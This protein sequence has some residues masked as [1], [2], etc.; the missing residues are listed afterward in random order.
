[1]ATRR[2]EASWLN[3]EGDTVSFGADL[4]DNVIGDLIKKFEMLDGDEEATSM[5][6]AV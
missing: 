6:D 4:N 5:E 2:V 3:D 1:M